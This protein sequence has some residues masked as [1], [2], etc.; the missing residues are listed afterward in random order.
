M[1]LIA[2]WA[3]DL[4]LGPDEIVRWRAAAA[5]HDVLRD[6]DPAALRSEL[7]PAF[8]DFA[9]SV[10]HGPAA[11]ERLRRLGVADAELLAAVAF[12]TVGHAD[13]ATLGRALYAADFLEPGRQWDAERRAAWRGRM[14][15]ELHQVVR[16]IV[17][18]R[19]EHLESRGARIQGQTLAFRD[20]VRADVGE[21]RGT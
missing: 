10:L 14:P 9:D 17:E 3:A 5:L 15:D 8:D 7:G 6:Q 12:H 4:Q 11:A 16:E 2:A 18:A 19:I 13:F 1:D 21:G 20:A